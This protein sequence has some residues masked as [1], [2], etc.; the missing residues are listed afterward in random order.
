MEPN[1]QSAME[2]QLKILREISDRLAAQEA[3]WHGRES[4]VAHHSASIHDTEVAAA[5]APSTTLSAELDAQV[6]ATHEWLGVVADDWGGLFGRGDD[7]DEQRFE[8]PIIA[9]NW[10]A[11]AGR[12][13]VLTTRVLAADACAAGIVDGAT[14]FASTKRSSPPLTPTRCSTTTASARSLPPT[15]NIAQTAPSMAAAALRCLTSRPMT[16]TSIGPSPVRPWGS[17]SKSPGCTMAGTSPRSGSRCGRWCSPQ[18]TRAHSPRRVAVPAGVLHARH[19]GH[20]HHGED[21]REPHRGRPQGEARLRARRLQ[22][23]TRRGPEQHQ[24]RPPHLRIRH[25]ATVHA[26]PRER[27]P[28]RCRCSVRAPNTS[29]LPPLAPSGRC[30]LPSGPLVDGGSGFGNDDDLPSI[31]RVP[32]SWPAGQVDISSPQTLTRHRS[33]SSEGAT[34][35][36]GGDVECSSANDFD[37]SRACN[38]SPSRDQLLLPSACS[39]GTLQL[40]GVSFTTDEVDAQ[41]MLDEMQHRQYVPANFVSRIPLTGGKKYEP[42][43]C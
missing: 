41:V 28:P 27:H 42:H 36:V 9:D 10:G 15:L 39:A 5:T 16:P 11:D 37:C 7:S 6:V 33:A 19:A 12:E 21:R 43:R 40:A 20:G 1:L 23:S 8:E 17:P 35:R 30:S 13:I 31:R 25:R 34:S 32:L 22:R 2:E 29:S 4:T 14:P 18:A 26:H 24:R 38:A 3:R